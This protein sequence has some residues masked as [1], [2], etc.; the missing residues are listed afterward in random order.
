MIPE[1]VFL[2]IVRRAVKAPSGHN[3]QPWLFTKEVNGICIMPDFTRALPT[4]DP[5]NRE[6]YISL[7]CAAE[8]VMIAARFYGYKAKLNNDL[9]DNQGTIKIALSKND[10]TEQAELFSFINARQTTR[11]LY[12]NQPVSMDV[13]TQL[14][15]MVAEAGVEVAFYIG[16]EAR[17]TFASYIFEANNIQMSNQKFKKE[18]I[19]WLR[20]SQKEAMQKGDGLYAAC[21]GLPS[22]GKKLGNFVVKYFITPRSEN[23]RFL[24]QFNKASTIAL[25]TTPE[26]NGENWVRMGMALQR[27]ALICTQKGLSYS[28]INSPCQIIQVRD[29]MMN[30]LPFAG[31]P[32]LLIRLGYS[33]K[34]PFSFRRRIADVILK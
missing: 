8:T 20:F 22:L 17:D 31:F 27:F 33:Q 9:L 25:F 28:Y 10:E 6:L 19:K 3:T 11:N 23:K 7:G 34:M 30:D 26:N 29:K 12:T 32:Q 16:N 21:T 13:L 2:K 4:A 5:E 18:L 1:D 15:E 14:K 24:Q